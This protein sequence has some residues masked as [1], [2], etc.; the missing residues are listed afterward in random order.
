M[1]LLIL[2][3]VL[4]ISA[5]ARQY[6]VQQDQVPISCEPYLYPR[7]LMLSPFDDVVNKGYGWELSHSDWK[8][9][10]DWQHELNR[11][12]EDLRVAW[13]AVETC[14]EDFNASLEKEK[15]A[16]VPVKRW[17]QF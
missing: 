10:V 4:F 1:R 17:W 3:L 9:L 11:F 15:P 8:V 2:V 5:C 6:Q 12:L 16:T 7:P 14:I 13:L